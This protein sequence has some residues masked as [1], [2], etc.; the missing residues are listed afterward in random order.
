[1]RKNDC[2]QKKTVTFS[3]NVEHRVSCDEN[4]SVSIN[5]IKK[6]CAAS[7]ILK[8][9]AAYVPNHVVVKTSPFPRSAAQ[10]NINY[11]DCDLGGPSADESETEL[12]EVSPD[13]R[14][15]CGLCRRQWADRIATLCVNCSAYMSKFQPTAL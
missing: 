5:V 15:R 7:G 1:M 13:G 12:D 10:T 8:N 14:L 6:T 2:R 4:D 9:T 11:T 3:D